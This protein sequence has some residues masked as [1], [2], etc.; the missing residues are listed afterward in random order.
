[1]SATST[2]M[3][4]TNFIKV[5]TKFHAFTSKRTYS[6]PLEYVIQ[7]LIT[8]ATPTKRRI[9]D[10]TVVKIK[11][12]DFIKVCISCF[13]HKMHDSL[14]FGPLAAGL[15]IFTQHLEITKNH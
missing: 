12:T 15:N 8:S 6:L 14:I 1:M 13:Y 4:C 10:G 5:C 3:L 9:R 11:C 7:P 2:E